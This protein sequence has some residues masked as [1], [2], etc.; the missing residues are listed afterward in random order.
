[1]KKIAFTLLIAT[2]C[3]TQDIKQESMSS[4]YIIFGHF[5]GECIGEQCV[6]IYKLTD[7]AIY[8]DTKDEYPSRDKAYN[9]N[10]ELLENSV[11]EKVKDLRKE[12][13]ADL[14]TSTSTVIGQ[15]DA[16]DWGG[17]YFEITDAGERRYWLIDKLETNI[18]E[19]LR[20]FV[21]KIE[22]KIELI[23]N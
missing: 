19:Y 23:N 18:P 4:D 14:L 8:E 1:M 22:G 7:N 5:Y 20:P 3:Q 15:P 10:F 17:I 6:E 2:A 11:F 9:G 13:P 21:E 16:G 12:I